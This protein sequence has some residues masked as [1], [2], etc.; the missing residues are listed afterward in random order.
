MP[1]TVLIQ[2]LITQVHGVRLLQPSCTTGVTKTTGVLLVGAFSRCFHPSTTFAYH[3][4]ILYY[5]AFYKIKRFVNDLSIARLN[6]NTLGLHFRLSQSTAMPL[7]VYSDT[8]VEVVSSHR[9]F[10]CSRFIFATMRCSYFRRTTTYYDGR[11]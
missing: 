7:P 4:V 5:R 3:R 11:V 6:Q 2:C 1:L 9:T 10:I 8:H